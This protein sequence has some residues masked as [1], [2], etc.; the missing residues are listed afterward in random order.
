MEID[1]RKIKT[2]DETDEP[3]PMDKADQR[4]EAEMKRIEGKAKEQ[5]A[6]G[7]QNEELARK[8]RRM[9]EDAEGELQQLREEDS[10]N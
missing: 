1:K 3:A 9:K 6:S 10:K 4:V 2:L 8:G 5:V 7:L